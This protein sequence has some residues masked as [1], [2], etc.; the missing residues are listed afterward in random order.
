[1]IDSTHQEDTMAGHSKWAN[2]KHRKGAQDARRGKLFTR[3][4]RE[5]TVAAREGGGDPD[6]NPRLRSAISA[7]RAANMPNDRI[8]RALKKG[9]GELDGGAAY[10]EVVYEGYGPGGVAVF[11]S[12]LTDNRNR[13]VSEVRHLFS[14]HGGKLGNPGDVARMFDRKGYIEV[15][16]EAIGEDDL[17]E[18]VLE[19]GA[20]DMEREDD[21]FVIYTAP[22]AFDDVR[23]ALESEGVTMTTAEVAMIPQNLVPVE[24][25]KAETVMSLLE[26]LDD[27]DDVQ[28][29]SANCQIQQTE[30][31]G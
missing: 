11:V 6:S 20:D 13:T 3:L 4:A 14:K 22:E 9:T 17:M 21:T 2:I 10:E 18:K 24:G 12:C 27:Q 5:V 19:A 8:D 26:A 15:P 23:E 31:S 16:A 25:S 1:V 30:A 7:A 29:V 28:K